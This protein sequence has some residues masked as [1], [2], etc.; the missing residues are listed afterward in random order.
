MPRRS[1]LAAIVSLIVAAS[2][3]A[4]AQSLS[5]GLSPMREEFRLAAGEI[6]TRV[7]RLSNASK[8]AVRVRAEVLDF[9]IDD[10]VTPQFAKHIASEA[11]FSCRSWLRINPMETDLQPESGMTVRYTLRVPP[12]TPEGGYHCAAGFR[13][14][15]FRQSDEPGTS[16]RSA[17][18]VVAAF[19]VLVGEPVIDGS[20]TGL[21][22]AYDPATERWQAVLTIENQ[23][24]RYFRPSGQLELLNE[25]EE[26][27][28]TAQ[29]PPIPVLPRRKQRV[30]MLLEKVEAG[31]SYTLRLQIDLGGGEIIEG[32]RVAVA[33]LPPP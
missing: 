23:G 15:A 21:G 16:I 33:E 26:T 28:E 30:P 2:G 32:S 19:Y 31:R 4:A 13:T 27:V 18:R 22:L 20:P 24:R 9:N 5:L 6:V 12:D 3:G 29:I 8:D 25:Q 11:I 17:V 14:L 7:L 1:T 10:M